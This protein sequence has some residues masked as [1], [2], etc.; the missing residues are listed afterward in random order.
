MDQLM[1]KGL[2]IYTAGLFL[3]AV[4]AF[5]LAAPQL[6]ALAGMAVLAT[7]VGIMAS[8]IGRDLRTIEI[9]SVPSR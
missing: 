9:T 7:I 3:T 8:A 6:S 1:T 2:K 4:M 5:V